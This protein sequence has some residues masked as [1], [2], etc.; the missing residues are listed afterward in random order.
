MHRILLKT[1][2]KSADKSGG[3]RQYIIPTEADSLARTLGKQPYGNHSH[4]Q[5]DYPHV[6]GCAL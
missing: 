3:E 5:T 4:S 6:E 1:I 2:E